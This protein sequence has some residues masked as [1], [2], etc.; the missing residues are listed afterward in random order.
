MTG[1]PVHEVW[2]LII[3]HITVVHTHHSPKLQTCTHT[4]GTNASLE[5]L[6]RK[7]ETKKEKTE[8]IPQSETLVTNISVPKVFLH[9]YNVP[10]FHSWHVKYGCVNTGF[11]SF[12]QCKNNNLHCGFNNKNVSRD[13]S[14]FLKAHAVPCAERKWWWSIN[15]TSARSVIYRISDWFWRT[16]TSFLFS[17]PRDTAAQDS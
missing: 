9:L 16:I 2:L 13:R 6:Y 5:E 11:S 15:W 8:D 7:K 17:K 12:A 10:Q 3:W 14:T 1:S 4:I